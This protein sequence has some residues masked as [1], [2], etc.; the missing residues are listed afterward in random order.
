MERPRPIHLAWTHAPRTL[1][2]VIAGK[3]RQRERVVVGITGPVG[4][5]KTTLA[6]MLSPCVIGTDCYLPDYEKVAYEERDRPHA[7]DHARLAADLALLRLGETADVPVWSFQTHRREG[8][9]KVSP[10]P[11]IICEGIH[12]LHAPL[13][14]LLDLSVY[15]EAPADVRWSRWEGM[16]HRR[17]RGWP[18]DEARA[19][20]D[21]VAEPTFG[22][23][24]AQ[25]R[26]GADYVV[27]NGSLR[28]P[29]ARAAARLVHPRPAHH[30]RLV[31]FDHALRVHRRPPAPCAPRAELD[32]L[33]GLA[34]QGR[35]RLERPP[36]MITLNPRDDNAHARAHERD[37][38]RDQPRSKEVRL[39]NPDHLEAARPAR[40][41]ERPRHR[42]RREPH[43]PVG[44][45]LITRIPIIAQ[46]LDG[47]N[48]SAAVRGTRQPRDQLGRL[49]AEH[50]PAE[51]LE[52]SRGHGALMQG[53]SP[54]SVHQKC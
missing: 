44:H 46:G 14:A 49:S 33:V 6:T 35:E 41:L 25:Y 29:E 48:A 20:F 15:V 18:A 3:L 11:V 28:Q 17:E 12:A 22:E 19:F 38:R 13:R 10:A 39:I 1:K 31:G 30:D 5:G 50:R 37:H 42:R 4:A 43:S 23:L 45:K 7:A 9:R 54:P 52:P 47:Q 26:A 2:E 27:L 34:Q 21:A 51:D 53:A 24:A 16:A 8:H 36:P 32:N 40:D